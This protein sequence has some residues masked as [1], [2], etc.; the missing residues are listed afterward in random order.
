MAGLEAYAAV[1]AVSDVLFLAI[2]DELSNAER[3]FA[4]GRNSQRAAFSFVIHYQG[5]TNSIFRRVCRMPKPTLFR[6]V[7]LIEKNSAITGRARYCAVSRLY[8]TIRW[9]VGGQISTYRCRM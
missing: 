3:S 1:A 7:Q 9:L 5:L 6:L 2:D 4:P 8:M